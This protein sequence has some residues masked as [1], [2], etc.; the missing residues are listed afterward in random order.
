MMNRYRYG[1]M[2]NPDVYIDETV[3]RMCYTHRRLFAKLA[4]AL[5][6]E[7]KNDKA[8]KALQKCSKELPEYNIPM[9]YLSGGADIAK[10]YALLGMK[11]KAKETIGKVWNTASQ[12]AAWYLSLDGNNFAMS[13]NEALTQLYIMREV[14][15]VTE[16]VDKNL[17]KQQTAKLN[18]LL[19]LYQSKGGEI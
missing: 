12:Y 15:N 2:N 19:N 8:A 7:G 6:S 16:L 18:V 5:I 3:M 10:A 1:G 4:L 9:D 14:I 13:Q 17:A 11:G